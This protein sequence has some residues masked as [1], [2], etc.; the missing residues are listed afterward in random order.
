[1]NTLLRKKISLHKELEKFLGRFI[2]K[3]LVKNK[4]IIKDI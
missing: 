2:L 3:M 4:K 1:M